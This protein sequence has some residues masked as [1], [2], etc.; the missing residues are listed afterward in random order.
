MH[1]AGLDS[2]AIWTGNSR[3]QATVGITIR[4]E[5]GE[6]VAGATVTGVWSDGASGSDSCVTDEAGH[7]LVGQS[8]IKSNVGVV[9]FTVTD[10]A[11]DGYTYDASSN[12]QSSISVSQPF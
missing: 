7:C 1:V 6:A 10:V 9:T 2:E 12:L 11:S 5:T 8:N 4:D 3:W